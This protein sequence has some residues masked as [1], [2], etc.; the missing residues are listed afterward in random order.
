MMTSCL[1]A[2]KSSIDLAITFTA[3]TTNSIGGGDQWLKGG[4]LELGTDVWHGLGIAARVGGETSS[5]ISSSGVPVSLMLTTFG[6]RYRLPI[7]KHGFSVYG[8]GLVGEANGFKSVYPAT[9][10]VISSANSLALQVGGGADLRLSKHFSYRLADVNWTRMQ[11][12]NS[13][14]NVQNH[15]QIGTGVVLRF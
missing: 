9:G 2:Q 3:D 14:T 4:T 12:P 11:F 6:P 5:S 1:Y 13:T 8:E 7:S 15:L 10:G